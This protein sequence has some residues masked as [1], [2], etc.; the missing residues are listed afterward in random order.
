MEEKFVRVQCVSLIGYGG[1]LD[2]IS[3]LESEDK[4]LKI[5]QKAQ[6]L[7]FKLISNSKFWKL[8]HH[9]NVLVRFLL[10]IIRM[11]LSLCFSGET[12]LVLCCWIAEQ[13]FAGFHQIGYCARKA[14]GKTRL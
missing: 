3:L 5:A 1:I 13:G 11:L 7:H 9:Q 2:Q 8:A 14:S 12:S 10:K 4:Q 6:E